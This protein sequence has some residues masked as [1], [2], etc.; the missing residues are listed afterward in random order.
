MLRLLEEGLGARIA[1]QDD[2]NTIALVISHPLH[3]PCTAFSCCNVSN[4]SVLSRCSCAVAIE[5]KYALKCT[6]K[7][8][9]NALNL[10]EDPSFFRK[11]SSYTGY[12]L[13]K[14]ISYLTFRT[15]RCEVG[16][17]RGGSEGVQLIISG[18]GG[19][20][21]PQQMLHPSDTEVARQHPFSP[22]R[23]RLTDGSVADMETS[24]GL[25]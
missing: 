14:Q 7:R 1:P 24:E 22:Q 6:T 15:D 17:S 25:S 19:I 20:G 8:E 3:T 5:V 10:V 21:L 9:T 4:V 23:C 16:G 11:S 13:H 2:L 18:S 12:T